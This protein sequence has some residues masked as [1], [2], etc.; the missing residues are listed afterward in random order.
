MI[1]KKNDTNEQSSC[2]WLGAW[3][4]PMVINNHGDDSKL[5]L[6]ALCVAAMVEKATIASG[7]LQKITIEFLTQGRTVRYISWRQVR[8]EVL[9]MFPY[10]EDLDPAGD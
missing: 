7:R 3:P 6:W 5:R 2:F 9:K 1:E 4:T 8:D 10:D